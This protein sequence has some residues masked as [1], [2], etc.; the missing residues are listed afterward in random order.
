MKGR[1]ECGD[2]DAAGF[3]GEF[4][5][6]AGSRADAGRRR[7]EGGDLP[8]EVHRGDE[9]DAPV[10]LS[11]GECGDRVGEGEEREA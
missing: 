4:G 3:Q 1:G 5:G 10:P 7:G 2:A 8:G 6:Y 9:S 11:G